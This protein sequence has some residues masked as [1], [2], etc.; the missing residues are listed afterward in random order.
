M[1]SNSCSLEI[2]VIWP[3]F[4]TLANSSFPKTL[5]I[6][7]R[8]REVMAGQGG[9]FICY[10]CFKKFPFKSHYDRHMISCG[11]EASDSTDV[12]RFQCEVCRKEFSKR[13]N[14][15]RHVKSCS[16]IG[17]HRAV[18][19]TS[20]GDVIGQ[21][22]HDN[23][24][25]DDIYSSDRSLRRLF[26][27]AVACLKYVF[28]ISYTTQGFIFSLVNY[29]AFKLLGHNIFHSSSCN[30]R[31]LRFLVGSAVM[32]FQASSF[33]TSPTITDQELSIYE[34]EGVT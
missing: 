7:C 2:L 28:C 3:T 26:A 11:C 9:Q 20:I 29:I 13:F 17:K 4:K 32:P 27:T 18:N 16:S 8:Q 10:K 6:N 19:N 25:I 22:K 14:F 12:K 34:S 5:N 21:Q 31:W 30:G 15:D 33:M 1:D 24:T 23:E